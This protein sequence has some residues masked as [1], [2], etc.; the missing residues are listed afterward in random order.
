MAD[1]IETPLW[2]LLSISIVISMWIPCIQVPIW[3]IPLRHPFGTSTLNLYRHQHVDP[4]YTGAYMADPVETL[5]WTSTLNLYRHQHVDPL[6]TGAYM[7][8]PVETLLWTLLSISIVISMWIPCIQ[9]PIWLIPLRHYFGLYSQS[10]SSS[11]CGS[12][13]YRCLYGLIPLRH[14]FGLYS[15]SLSSLKRKL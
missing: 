12:L 4:L 2:T 8:D 6:Y 10:L 1:P 5:L 13:V 9:V 3:L 15:Q 14:Y 11:A 7:A